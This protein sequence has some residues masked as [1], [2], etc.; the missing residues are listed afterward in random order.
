VISH[1]AMAPAH[2]ADG[3]LSETARE[4]GEARKG[5]SQAAS[6]GPEEIAARTR[7]TR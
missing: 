2:V 4:L 1:V 7:D 3:Q 6:R 5:M